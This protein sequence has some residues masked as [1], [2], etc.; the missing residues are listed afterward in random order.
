[1]GMAWA[2]SVGAYGR[3]RNAIAGDISSTGT[4]ADDEA[5]SDAAALPPVAAAISQP[6]AA[7]T[8]TNSAT[9]AAV[10]EPSLQIAPSGSLE[11]SPALSPAVGRASASPTVAAATSSA[12]SA[13]NAG[14]GLQ[15]LARLAPNQLPFSAYLCHAG[16]QEMVLFV[17]KYANEDL[18]MR[19]ASSISTSEYKLRNGY[20]ATLEG[21]RRIDLRCPHD[22][23]DASICNFTAFLLQFLFKEGYELRSATSHRSTYLSA[24]R[25]AH[26]L[27]FYPL[28]WI[29]Q[30]L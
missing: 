4:G 16:S 14:L 9:A 25:T 5:S 30:S 12:V 21:T 29:I 20:T 18:V 2:S 24:Q 17:C 26:F 10:V 22:E 6:A 19:L 28:P 3:D 13:P 8:T 27:W 7:L 15:Q 11:L 1:M 23:I